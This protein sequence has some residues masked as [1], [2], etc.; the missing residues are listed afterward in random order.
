M[1]SLSIQ[2][3]RKQVKYI[4]LRIKRDGSVH[5]TVPLGMTWDAAVQWVQTKQPWLEARL[6]A[7]E[8]RYGSYQ[9]FHPERQQIPLWGKWQDAPWRTSTDGW[10]EEA[11]RRWYRSQLEPVW[12]KRL[13]F[14]QAQMNEPDVQGRLRWMVS[15]WGS[16]IPSKRAITLH[17]GLAMFPP[18]CLDY[19]IVHELAHLAVPRHDKAFYE[20]IGT[21]MNGW[22]H[23][24]NILRQDRPAE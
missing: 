3:E 13:L 4:L 14:W 9:A 1:V 17:A 2:Y 11:A 22:K 23:W 16:C 12:K 5:V 20:R 6:K 15:R 21:V 7:Q 10:T 8:L 19:V 18:K 24:Q